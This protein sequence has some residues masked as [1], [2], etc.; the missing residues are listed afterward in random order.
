MT[1]S[2]LLPSISKNHL[3]LVDIHGSLSNRNSSDHSYRH[4]LTK[5]FSN[6]I[7]YGDQARYFDDEIDPDLK[8][9]KFGTVSTANVGPNMNDSNVSKVL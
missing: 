2:Q 8:H 3:Y 1:K 6:R 7:L 5:Y 4:P 9:N